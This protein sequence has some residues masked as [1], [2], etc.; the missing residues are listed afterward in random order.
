MFHTLEKIRTQSSR[1]QRTFIAFSIS[2][3]FT[4]VIFVMWLASE[5]NVPQVV[6]QEQTESNTPVDTLSKNIKDAW[7]S[8]VGA[9]AQFG[10]VIQ[11][12]DFS[13][14]IEYKN[15]TS[16]EAVQDASGQ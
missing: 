7:G 16:T 6:V 1:G 10:Q 2:L 9:S 8:L 3:L 12:T 4:G 14:T 5:R 15:S 13:S 11:N